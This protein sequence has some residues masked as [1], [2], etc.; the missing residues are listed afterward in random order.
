[1]DSYPAQPLTY[2]IKPAKQAAKRHYGSHPYFTK[3]A[4]NV[5]QGYIE[6]FSSPGDTVLDPFGGS[7]VTT[8]ESLVLRR[9]AVYVD[10]S[11]WATFLGWQT[12]IAPVDVGNLQDAFVSLEERCRPYLEEVWATPDQEMGKQPVRDW[13]PKKVA[14]PSNADVEFVE[15]LFTP[16]ML[17]GL[18]HLRAGIMDCKD[19]SLRNLLLMAFSATLVRINRTFLSTKNRR[20]SRGGSAIFSIYRYKVAK[21]PVELPL[22]K[23]FTV[24]FDRLVE[25]KRE[26]NRLIGDFYREGDTAVFRQGSATRLL[27]FLKPQSIDYIYTDPPYGAHIAYLDLSTMWAAWLGFEIADEDRKQEVIEGGELQKTRDDYQTLLAQSLEQMHEVLKPGA[28]LSIVF[29]HRDTTY[30]DALVDACTGAG[31]QYANT[32]VQ[33][34]G[35]VWSMHKKKNPLRVLSGELVLN[36]RK[37]AARVVP[38]RPTTVPCDPVQVV[39]ACCEAEILHN[40][41]ATTEELHHAVVPKLLETGL[42]RAFS[43]QHGDLVPVLTN[44]FDFQTGTGKWHLRGDAL[45]GKFAGN[46]LARYH[47]ARFLASRY[48]EGIPVEEAEVQEHVRLVLKGNGALREKAIRKVLREVGTCADGRH[49]HPRTA[50]SESLLF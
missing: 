44:Y 39:R 47:I 22:W 35:V 26:T 25:A 48:D 18:A 6:H 19:T 34:V 2:A 45:I 24:R 13:Y 42:L 29:A 43:K 15:E 5:V 31:F 21:Q 7:G 4:W 12:A 41:G 8:V 27:D 17:H 9:K 14:L 16:R 32:V 36:F 33:P 40:L 37:P 46:D 28:W 23:Q 30:W 3:R 1:M 38:V 50:R 20:E 11:A 10:I 49:W